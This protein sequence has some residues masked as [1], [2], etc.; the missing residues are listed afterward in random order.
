VR[1][2]FIHNRYQ[3]EGGEDVAVE[4][5]TALLQEKGHSVKA[6]LFQNE[7]IHSL[8]SKVTSGLK[9]FY[10]KTSETKISVAIEEFKPDLIH[11]H[12]LF[13][14]ASPSVLYAAKKHRVP[15][16]FT[17][18]NYRLVCSNALLMRNNQVC[19]LCVNQS[20][21]VSGI[22][23]KCYR[24]SAVES[25]LVTGITGIHK[26][27]KTWNNYVDRYIALTEFSKQKFLS[28][29]LKLTEQQISI[30]PNFVP[31]TK[32]HDLP[33][34]NYYLY[35]GRLSGEKGIRVLMEAFKQLP[36]ASLVIIGDGPERS[37][38]DEQ[39]KA[40]G[41]IFVAGK[42]TKAEVMES[43]SRCRAL[44]FPS[45]CYEGLP[46]TILEAFSSGTPVIASRLGAMKEM[47]QDG[48]NGLHF[49]PNDPDDLKN[50]IR[51]FNEAAP[52]QEFNR[53]ARLT[54]EEKYHPD[55]HYKAIMSIY[56]NVIDKSGY[57]N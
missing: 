26:L 40:S 13:F 8:R 43:M 16:I 35:V 48:Y 6:L 50:C 25:A 56:Q 45:V 12:N 55:V 53:H 5:E 31:D 11:I 7:H 2:L 57:E 46:F 30:V 33:R 3:Y 17:L 20:F 36:Q 49:R 1:I 42:K 34:E 10:N 41:N 19:E 37:F 28:S 38:V 21:P 9:A 24:N 23:Y 29:S 18:H 54:Y 51:K 22:R 4:L 27:K 44:V 39:S 32:Q 52:R 47:I 15:V 14:D